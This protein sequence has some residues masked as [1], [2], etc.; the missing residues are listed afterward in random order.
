MTDQI[1]LFETMYSCRAMRRLILAR[2]D[3]Q[4]KQRVAELNRRASEDAAREQVEHAE[5]LPQTPLCALATPC[6]V[7]RGTQAGAK[8]STGP[9]R[10]QTAPRYPVL[11]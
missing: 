4:Q 11:R 7:C 2:D 1:G 6:G 5:P 8:N 3:D 10:G 9:C